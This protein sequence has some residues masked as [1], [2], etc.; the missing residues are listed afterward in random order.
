MKLLS[1]C[2]D[3]CDGC[4]GQGDVGG[5]RDARDFIF[6]FKSFSLRKTRFERV[7]GCVEKILFYFYFIFNI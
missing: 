7:K 2:R 6:F 5:D 1:Y 3:G 4:N